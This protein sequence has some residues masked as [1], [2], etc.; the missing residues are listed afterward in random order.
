LGAAQASGL[1]VASP[2][3]SGQALKAAPPSQPVAVAVSLNTRADVAL[4]AAI[5][6]LPQAQQDAINAIVA[7]SLSKSAAEV[8]DAQA[9]LAA[10]DAAL[11]GE[12]ATRTEAET[13]A[14]Q[15]A[16]TVQA[17]TAAQAAAEA[18]LAAKTNQ[19]A[20]AAALADEQ[21][22][23]SLL[24]NQL[25]SLIGWGILVGLIYLFVHFILPS[26][27]AQFPQVRVLVGIYNFLTSIFS[28]HTVVVPGAGS[29]V[30]TKPTVP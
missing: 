11:H 3:P 2:V 27:V 20:A 6:N 15:L 24:S 17:T 29:S 13:K 25:K 8:A 9:K 4:T 10:S 28:S 12:S 21:A 14:A 16:T 7:E 5:G 23:G 26:L 22:K 19:V 30:T 18:A 1:M